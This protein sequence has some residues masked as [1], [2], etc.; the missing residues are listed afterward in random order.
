MRRVNDNNFEHIRERTSSAQLKL[1][2]MCQL[3]FKLKYVDGHEPKFDPRREINFYAGNKVHAAIEDYYKL[4]PPVDEISSTVMAQLMLGWKKKM[5]HGVLETALLCA[6]NFISFET[7]RRLQYD[8][9][10]QSEHKLKARGFYGIVDFFDAHE[11]CLIDFK[12]NK[13]DSI[14]RDFKIQACIYN[15]LVNGSG[16]VNFYFL[17]TNVIKTYVVEDAI[18]QDVLRQK[19][20]VIYALDNNEFEAADH[21]KWCQFSY[22]CSRKHRY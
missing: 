18:E 5:P 21:C 14:K 20:D 1:F 15:W 6:K 2:G 3:A 19:A 17:Y 13:R 16:R 7:L 12:T 4:F 22:C 11:A 8:Y 9:I 10:P